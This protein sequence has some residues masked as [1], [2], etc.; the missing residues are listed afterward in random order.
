MC[1]AGNPCFHSGP[2]P[3]VPVNAGETITF[4]GR[5]DLFEGPLDDLL[6]RQRQRNADGAATDAEPE[7]T[8]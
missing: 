6:E 8:E 7:D 2:G 5:I 1:N 3:A 4:R